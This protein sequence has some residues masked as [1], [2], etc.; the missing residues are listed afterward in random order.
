MC[1][2]FDEIRLHQ[3]KRVSFNLHK[4]LDSVG[5]SDV[6]PQLATLS[7]LCNYTCI[8]VLNFDPPHVR[9]QTEQTIS[10][11]YTLCL[12][13]VVTEEGYIFKKKNDV[14]V[15]S[16]WFISVKSLLYQYPWTMFQRELK[17]IMNS[18]I[19]YS[20]SMSHRTKNQM[21]LR[22]RFEKRDP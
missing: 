3:L 2:Y 10:W 13:V 16:L 14:L 7:L 1:I 12:R 17:K 20:I 11:K 22:S 15:L 21:I 19:L 18:K 5:H 6:L 8:R 9:H 4:L